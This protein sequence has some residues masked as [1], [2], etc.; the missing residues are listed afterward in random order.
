METLHRTSADLYPVKVVQFGEGNF[1][2]AFIDWMIDEL[3]RK[4]DFGG[5]VQMIQ[6]LEKGMGDML[7]AQDGLYTLILRG[8]ADGKQVEDMR[9]IESV[10][11][12]FNA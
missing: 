7:N 4:A 12:C 10:R 5:T 1:L 9:V 3:N 2:R 8:I 11:G 6:P